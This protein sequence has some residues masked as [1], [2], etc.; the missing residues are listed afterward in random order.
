MDRAW[1]ACLVQKAAAQTLRKYLIT[2]IYD[3]DGLIFRI[4]QNSVCTVPIGLQ[5]LCCKQ[6]QFK[7]TRLSSGLQFPIE[8]VRG[9]R[10]RGETLGTLDT[11]LSNCVCAF[12]ELRIKK[13]Q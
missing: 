10:V 8:P 3:R 4:V 6:L 1:L 9:I 2:A 13:L 7:V 5:K 11:E 12:V